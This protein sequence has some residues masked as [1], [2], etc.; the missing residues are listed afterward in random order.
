MMS[1]LHVQL[2]DLRVALHSADS[3]STSHMPVA[4]GHQHTKL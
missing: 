1:E 4:I 3:E 2:C